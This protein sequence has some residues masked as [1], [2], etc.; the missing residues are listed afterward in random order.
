MLPSAKHLL[1]A[2]RHE[3]QATAA[4]GLS[5][6]WPDRARHP[7]SILYAVHPQGARQMTLPSLPK[8]VMAAR[9]RPR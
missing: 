8:S 5:F 7:S 3:K 1:L 6:R 9:G 4:L 2:P